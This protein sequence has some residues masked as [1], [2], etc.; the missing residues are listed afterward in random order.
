ML[1]V[2]TLLVV[3]AVEVWY[4]IVLEKR[5]TSQYAFWYFPI[6]QQPFWWLFVSFGNKEPK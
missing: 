2:K 5:K 4:L 3:V 6:W 1:F